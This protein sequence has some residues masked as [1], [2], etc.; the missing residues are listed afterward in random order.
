MHTRIATLIILF[1]ALTL[2]AQ[3]E[4]PTLTLEPYGFV[5]LNA[6]LDFQDM[7]NSDLFRP[8]LI[9]IDASTRSAPHLF[10]SAKQSR[11]GLKIERRVKEQALKGRIEAD[12]HSNADQPGGLVRLRHAYFQY[13][14]WTVGQTW[15]NFYDI[16]SR[17][18]IVDFEGANSAAL[19]RVPQLRYTFSVQDQAI[20][21][22]LE[23]PIEQLTLTDSVKVSKQLLPDLVAAW[24]YRWG[25]KNF[26]KVAALA[27]QLRYERPANDQP[28]SME[29]A[30]L[31]AGGMM[32]SAKVKATARDYLKLQVIGGRGLARYIRGVRNLGYDAICK[33]D[34]HELEAV[35]ITGGF[36]AYEHSWSE[37][38]SS[39]VLLGGVD[40]H[41]MEEFAA[42]DLDYCIYGS[43]N[44][45][46]SPVPDICVGLE[47][48]HGEKQ[49][50]S[51]R[52]GQANRVQMAGTMRF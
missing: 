12:F 14:G 41:Q 11:V 17:A 1:Y 18:K 10:F 6:T 20:M 16:E 52:R 9:P 43:A 47:F 51:G 13:R 2:S 37:Q 19:Y 22:S 50:L 36:V 34:C 28:E 44:I 42:D 45:F 49:E 31:W 29:L 24:K 33:S 23:N 27:R 38:W 21:L 35:G 39:T 7:G 46:Y 30:S 40:I 3:E 26:V 25:E 48:L 5:R 8:A 32:A 4:P 15:S